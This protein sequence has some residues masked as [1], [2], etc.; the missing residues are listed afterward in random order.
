[1]G[2]Y[3]SEYPGRDGAAYRG[4]VFLCYDSSYFIDG[5]E[6]DTIQTRLATNESNCTWSKDEYP[7]AAEG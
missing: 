3:P 5:D 2:G 6:L 7:A 4:L 1:M